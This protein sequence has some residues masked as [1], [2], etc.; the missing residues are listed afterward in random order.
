MYSRV[1]L[2]GEFILHIRNLRIGFA[3]DP[4]ELN[5]QARVLFRQRLGH[6][7]LVYAVLYLVCLLAES[8]CIH[9]IHG[10]LLC[11]LVGP[12]AQSSPGA[13]D[14]GVWTEAAQNA[15][16]VVLTRIEVGDDSVVGVGEVGATCR[17]GISLLVSLA[18]KAK[19]GGTIGAEYMTEV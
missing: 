4:V 18:E 13:L 8:F 7:L 19:P 2:T 16:L 17:A 1:R 3:D 12:E 5:T 15:R 10:H 11:G 14:N 6:V 9:G